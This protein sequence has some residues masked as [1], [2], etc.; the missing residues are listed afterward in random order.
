MNQLLGVLMR[1]RQEPVAVTADIEQM[2]YALKVK[3]EHRRF[4]RFLWYENNNP[5]ADIVT[6]QMTIHIFG[7]K[8]SPAVSISGLRKTAQEA[9]KQFGSDVRDLVENNFYIMNDVLKSLPTVEDTVNLLKRTRDMLATANIRLHKFASSSAEV[10]ASFD[11]EELAPNLTVSDLS[12]KNEEAIQRTLGVC[13]DLKSDSFTFRVAASNN[14]PST[15]R[16][17][18]SEVNGV[19]DLIGLAA[20]VVIKGQNASAGNDS[21]WRELG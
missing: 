17:V 1:F 18:L 10:L 15:K 19:Y 2:F 14:K 9:E 6:Y 5:A 11:Q 13:W 16:M 8:P 20:P 21:R 12:S 3:D 7:N 4:L